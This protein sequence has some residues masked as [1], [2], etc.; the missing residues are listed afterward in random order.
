MG[1]VLSFNE[2]RQI[3]DSLPSGSMKVIASHLN[4]SIDEV[5]SFFGS[6]NFVESEN[7][8]IHYEPGPDGGLL[9]IDNPSILNEAFKILKNSTGR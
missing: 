9:M 8:G 1:L 6:D 4:L 2:L 5:R 7:S 3:K